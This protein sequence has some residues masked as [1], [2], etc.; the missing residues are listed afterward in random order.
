[1]V[2]GCI[3]ENKFHISLNNFAELILIQNQNKNKA[4]TT[5]HQEYL[6]NISVVNNSLSGNLGNKLK[7]AS[8]A[9]RGN[10]GNFISSSCKNVAV[11][12]TWLDGV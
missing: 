3:V 7:S 8:R 4:L 6:C 2:F 5:W 9:L 12:L 10:N 11:V 1:M